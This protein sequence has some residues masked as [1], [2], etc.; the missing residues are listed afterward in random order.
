MT[1]IDGAK[2]GWIVCKIIN[3]E[4]NIFFSPK[5]PNIEEK[6]LI[7]IPIG[8]PENRFRRCDIQAKQILSKRSG[9]IFLV[10]VRQALYANTYEEALKINRKFTG[11]GFPK[12]LWNIRKKIQEI[13]QILISNPRFSEI[14]IES[15]PE[16]CFLKLS[17]KLLPPKKT[18]Q[19]FLTRIEILENLLPGFKRK[20]H[21]IFQKFQKYKYDILD[22]CILAAALKFPL[23]FIPEQPEYDVFGIPMRIAYPMVEK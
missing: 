8:I 1:G 10:P 12:Q 21:K 20:T 4:I 3:E 14:L 11:K 7:D 16:I 23:S 18:P 15:H 5:I 13:D 22:A 17:G 6:T 2:G 19:G 9:S